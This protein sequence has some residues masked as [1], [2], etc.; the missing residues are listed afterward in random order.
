MLVLIKHELLFPELP[1]GEGSGR[2]THIRLSIVANT[3]T[4]ELHKFPSEVLIRSAFLVSPA[5]QPD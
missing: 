5:V 1:T 2:F 3:H 4:E